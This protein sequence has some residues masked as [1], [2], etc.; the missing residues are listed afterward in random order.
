MLVGREEFNH[1]GI[2]AMAGQAEGTEF[3]GNFLTAEG[4]EYAEAGAR[5]KGEG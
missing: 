5:M 1:R 2:A 4:A 3:D